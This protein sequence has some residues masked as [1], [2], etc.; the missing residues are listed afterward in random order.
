MKWIRR[1]LFAVAISVTFLAVCSS[2]YTFSVVY[3][4]HGLIVARS[5][6]G[7]IQLSSNQTFTIEFHKPAGNYLAS[8]PIVWQRPHYPNHLLFVAHWLVNL[9][10]WSLFVILWRT[11]RKYSK[12]HCQRCGYD[13]TGNESG[14][15]PEC[16]TEITS[17]AT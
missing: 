1:M 8:P 3:G 5:G 16:D 2:Q 12:G 9:I 6:Y 11:R 13:L 14:R 4:R 15:C 10:A 17:C 7:L